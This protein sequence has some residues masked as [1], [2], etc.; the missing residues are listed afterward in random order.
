ML[1]AGLDLGTTHLK[2]LLYDDDT[3][4]IVAVAT[5]PTP[6]TTTGLHAS[7]AADDVARVAVELL[8]SA[9]R[10]V[11]GPTRVGGIAV[12]GVGE[13]VVLVDAEGNPTGATLAWYDP[14][15]RDGARAFR[16]QS[17]TRLHERFPPDGS[18]SLF[19]LLW[20]RSH[21]RGDLDRCAR[22]VD[23]TGFLMM[24]LG[25][26]AT[27]DWSHASRTGL[28]DPEAFAWDEETLRASG[29]TPSLCP[30]LVPS[31]TVVGGLGTAAA[32]R[33]G[34][35]AGTPLVAGG[36]DH[37]CGAFASGVRETGELYISAGTS[38]AQLV[39]TDGPVAPVGD[40][41]PLDQ[42]RFVD[43]A[44]WYVHLG[45]PF[46]RAYQQWRGLLFGGED[47]ATVESEVARASASEIGVLFR[48]AELDRGALLEG[49]P[50]T[51]DRGTVLR[52]VVEGSAVASARVTRRLEGAAGVRGNRIVVAGQAAHDGRWRALRS[53]LTHR[54][55]EL[56][57]E[58]QAAA[59]G[60]ALLAQRGVTGAADT[61]AVGRTRFEP[62]SED[63]EFA[64]V[65]DARYALSP[66]AP[67]L[68]VEGQP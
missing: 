42:G 12:A 3:R 50:L 31:G 37:F 62:G 63:L 8:G 48:P 27:M 21:R 52:A 1:W 26:P 4:R 65:L 22:V 36:H 58:P 24:R 18:F 14:R 61:E 54:S 15:G 66:R 38:E 43:A 11:G 41:L 6:I 57:D 59:L 60:A 10:Q 16:R 44:H 56:V 40:G 67:G 39:L 35:A 13:E 49:V 33:L 30:D 68:G 9:M 17:A 45:N 28:F 53:G 64:A 46:G 20:L 47:E 55:I 51:A 29:L 34:I 7:H 19:K 5:A 23:L 2:A 32:A 25:A